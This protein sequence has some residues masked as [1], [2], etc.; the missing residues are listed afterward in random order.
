VLPT[1]RANV[2]R[3]RVSIC[4]GGGNLEIEVAQHLSC[5]HASAMF[6]PPTLPNQPFTPMANPNRIIAL[7]C[8]VLGESHTSFRVDIGDSGTVYDLIKA[9]A[10]ILEPD[11]RPALAGIGADELV[12]W[13]VSSLLYVEYFM[14]TTLLKGIH[15][16]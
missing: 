3:V 15:S 4:G 9:I 8:W 11:E 1:Y 5:T 13:K 6:F 10:A 2:D 12:L 7:Y 14:L 16:G